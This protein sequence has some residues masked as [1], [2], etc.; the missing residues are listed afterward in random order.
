VKAYSTIRIQI[1]TRLCSIIQMQAVW[2]RRH[3][4]PCN[5]HRA[6]V[7]TSRTG[8][9]GVHFNR[10]KIKTHKTIIH[11]KPWKVSV[12]NI[13]AFLNYELREKNSKDYIQTAT[14]KMCRTPNQIPGA[15][16]TIQNTKQNLDYAPTSAS[17]P[18]QTTTNRL[19]DNS[20]DAKTTNPKLSA[21]KVNIESKALWDEF[22]HLGTEMIVTKAGRFVHLKNSHFHLTIEIYARLLRRMFPTFQVKLSEMDPN[23]D[24]MLMM[25]FVPLDDKR[26]RYAFYR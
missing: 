11:L 2:S 6:M 24:Y 21:I 10:Q 14:K 3:P 20:P 5:Q 25:D 1:I 9:T 12:S 18:Y 8:T 16:T 4:R 23:G 13:S 15:E 17:Y 7:S 19:N 26:Y 22:D